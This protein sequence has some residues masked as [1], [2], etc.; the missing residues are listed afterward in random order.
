M[1]I[2]EDIHNPAQD[3]PLPAVYTPSEEEPY[4]NPR[5]LEYFKQKLLQW[6]EKL[7]QE[8][9]Q[10]VS[11]LKDES[12]REIDFLDQGA[13]ETSI[14]LRLRSRDRDRKLIRKI[15]DALERIQHGTYG[16][17]EET[18]EEIGLKRLEARPTATLSLEAQKWHERQERLYSTKTRT[19]S[20]RG[21]PFL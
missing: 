1:E 15:D 13:L 17:C 21:E 9:D 7:I 2:T 19:D 10:T 8:S 11:L 14:S 12:V 18:E 16:Y 20:S 6:R 3:F 5:Q 4:M